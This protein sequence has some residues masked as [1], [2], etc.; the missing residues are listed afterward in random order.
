[1]LS[2]NGIIVLELILS[3]VLM[4][5][6]FASFGNTDLIADSSSDSKYEPESDSV[7]A[8]RKPGRPRTDLSPESHA[9]F[10]RGR[11]GESDGARSGSSRKGNKPHA[12]S[13]AG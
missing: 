4:C 7:G 5:L 13:S 6:I 12:H 9:H 11:L 3:V 1:M 10:N 8:T 2:M